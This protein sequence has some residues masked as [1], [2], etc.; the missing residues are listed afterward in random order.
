MYIKVNNV[1]NL[2]RMKKNDSVL[3]AYS[4]YNV[5]VLCI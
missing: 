3:I 4:Q 2:F 1:C 5:K